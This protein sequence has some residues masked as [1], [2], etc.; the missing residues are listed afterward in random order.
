MQISRSEIEFFTIGSYSPRG[1][2][3]EAKKSQK[4]T[5][6]F[7]GGRE[8]AILAAI[9]F[10]KSIDN[11]KVDSFFG[12]DSILVPVPKSSLM[13]PDTL[14]PSKVIAELLVQEGF[15]KIVLPLVER[16]TSIPRSSQFYSAST[17]PSL[18]KHFNS[19][20][21]KIELLSS[22]KFTLIDDILTIGRTSFAC[23]QKLA[24]A[25]PDAE[26][27]CFAMLRTRSRYFDV[28][29]EATFSS[30]LHIIDSN[31][32]DDVRRQDD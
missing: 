4:F 14:W 32:M 10:L 19:L 20:N 16:T 12:N 18:E 26:V 7:K 29:A 30:L 11:S 23:A 9:Q 6:A 1:V 22:P 24:Q 21:V 31:G 3:D 5:H 28:T 17:R 15:G 8:Q 27:R 25:Y 13:S 2:S